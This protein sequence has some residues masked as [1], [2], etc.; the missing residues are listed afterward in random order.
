[1][2]PHPISTDT[3]ASPILAKPLPAKALRQQSLPRKLIRWFLY[4]VGVLMLCVVLY[5]VSGWT[6]GSIPANASFQQTPDGIEI[7]ILNNGIHC[8]LA[9]PMDNDLFRWRSF[10]VPAHLTA[11]QEQSQYVLLGWGNRRF[12]LETRTWGDSNASALPSIR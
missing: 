7:A 6:L 1:M 11:H 5:V 4:S 9:L 8:D 3:P 10:L 2:N 12:Y